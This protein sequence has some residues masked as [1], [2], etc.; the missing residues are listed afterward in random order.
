MKRYIYNYQTIV[1]FSESVINHAVLLRCQ[2]AVGSYM[3]VDEE[4]LVI[5]PGFR[6]TK[7][8]DQLGNRIIY[9]S[10]R[11]GHLSLA[12]VSAGLVSMSP[13]VI[14]SERGFNPVY[15][16]QTRMTDIGQDT[17]D[18]DAPS[19]VTATYAP[20]LGHI[21]EVAL[22]ICHQVYGMMT[23]VPFSTN[24]ETT[25]S[26]VMQTLQGVCQDYAHLMIGLCRR[27]GIPARYVCGFLEGT[28]ET[29]AWVEVY[30]GYSWIGFDPTNDCRIIYGYVK[31]AHGRDAS[32]CPVSRGLYAGQALQQTQISVTLK[33]I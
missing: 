6:L 33:E 2:P 26:Q 28:G 12:Y 10:Q 19:R 30:D 22:D 21:A 5:S 4:H 11:E 3:T 29:H 24:V 18:A 8:V 20:E 13:Y 23:Y 14:R 15:L 25:A 9:G 17:L 32:D 27:Q 31:L 7:G 1:T 16:V